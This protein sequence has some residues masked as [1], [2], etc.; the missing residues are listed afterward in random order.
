MTE[1]FG[2]FL[3]RQYHE[4]S[5]RQLGKVRGLPPQAEFAKWLG[6]PTTSLSMWINDVRLPQG[7]NVDKLADK[8]GVVVY[9]VLSLPRR[10]PKNKKLALIAEM[11]NRLP[12]HLQDE[13]YEI[14]KNTGKK[15]VNGGS[16]TQ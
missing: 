11:W 16:Q 3:L 10:M 2:N 15:E 12:E 6:V 13:W 14:A 7:E 5:G 8:L 4:W 1:S 9:D